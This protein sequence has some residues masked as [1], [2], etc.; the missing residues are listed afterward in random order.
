M[1]ACTFRVV[2]HGQLGKK[3]YPVLVSTYRI[4]V[5]LDTSLIPIH[6]ISYQYTDS[7]GG[8]SMCSRY[9][10]KLR[11][12]LIHIGMSLWYV[13]HLITSSEVASCPLLHWYFA[14]SAWNVQFRDYQYLFHL[15]KLFYQLGMTFST[16]LH[17]SIS[18]N[19]LIITF[20]GGFSCPTRK[21]P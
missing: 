1:Y 5:G 7:S 20:L 17:P 8:I 14:K 2:T 15:E 4:G 11:W 21:V 19:I 18:L 13:A 10:T 16:L 9:P 3:P 12:W 6:A